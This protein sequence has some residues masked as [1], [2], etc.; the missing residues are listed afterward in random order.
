MKKYIMRI[1]CILM[2]ICMFSGCSASAENPSEGQSEELSEGTNGGNSKTK[3]DF[4]DITES[5]KIPN[6]G[7][8]AETVKD[9]ENNLGEKVTDQTMDITFELLDHYKE[10][11]I[12]S[13]YTQENEN[14]SYCNVL[15]NR[16]NEIEYYTVAREEDGYYIWRYTLRE[17]VTK[18]E[19]D[20]NP[21]FWLYKKG[22]AW[23]REPVLWLEGIKAEIDQG[24][25]VPFRGEDQNEYAWYIGSEEKPHLV[26]RMDD[27]Y[28]EIFISGWRVTEYAA[29]AVL[30]NGYIVSADLGKECFIYNPEN[31]SLLTSFKCG[32]YE[33]I[34]VNGNIVY[35]TTQ[36]GAS[37]QRFDAEEMNFLPTIEASFDDSVRIAL[38]EEDVY[39]CTPTGIFRSK[40][41]S[42]AF[43]KVMEG[44][45]FYFTK[46][47]GVLL[48]FFVLE[49]V[50][51]VVYGE[52]GVSIKKYLPSGNE[53]ET[54]Q[55]FTVYSLE[56]ND[57]LVDLISEFQ[58]LY[59]EVELVYETG[60]G[61]DG[62]ITMSDRIRALNTRILAGD[63]PDVL[64]LDGLPAKSYIEKG[65][66]EDLS[67]EFISL[68]DNILPNILSAYMI[69][70]KIFM[71][72]LRITVPM[73][74]VSGVNQEI[75]SD[76]EAL[77][78]YSEEEGGL[79]GEAYTYADLFNILYYNYTP[80]ILSDNGL[81]NREAVSAFFSLAKRFCESE[82]AMESTVWE[83][84]YL[85]GDV[86][87]AL[88]FAG[89]NAV[90]G[91]LNVDGAYELGIIPAAVENRGGELVGNQDRFF[92]NALLGMNHL[93]DKKELSRL[94]LQFVFSY[95]AQERVVIGSG[96]PILTRIV[97]GYKQLDLS[98][99]FT[100]NSTVV[101]RNFTAKESARMVEVVKRLHTPFTVEESVWEIISGVGEDYLKGKKNLDESVDEVVSRLQL[102]FYEQ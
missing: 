32:W 81:V 35:I 25:V 24:R 75:Y 79:T 47:S 27:S 76:L 62:S 66:L 19:A 17:G 33:S 28:T 5:D 84:N 36:G 61:A 26:K 95:E 2:V 23:E 63:G 55:F 93:S 89:G 80:N 65:I 54:S 77:V 8:G 9:D 83:S 68:K 98:G 12:P 59:P 86:G 73:F 58:N 34:C 43:Q 21:D 52:D 40:Q 87:F 99:R 50:F 64:L 51:Y 92:P 100:G 15:L 69:G 37:V 70:D 56:R 74:M 38:Q 60:Q 48:K 101:L 18:E 53:E 4:P 30:E 96:Y 88:S 97:D 90:L 39:V 20:G 57:L 67:Q 91:F 13:V 31:G 82:R 49:D 29:V 11:S 10:K 85:S 44:G 41:N 16:D 46:E 72:P 78:E 71:L 6:K 3:E 102:Y 45:T 7:D 94:F 14:E 1:I 42:K 22:I